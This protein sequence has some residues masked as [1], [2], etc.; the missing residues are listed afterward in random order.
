M[1]NLQVAS[2]VCGGEIYEGEESHEC[3]ICNE[4]LCHYCYEEPCYN[5][6]AHVCEKCKDKCAMCEESICA[7]CGIVHGGELGDKRYCSQDCVNKALEERK[8]V[9]VCLSHKSK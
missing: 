3:A 4:P 2:C 7:S 1:D 6:G 8:A 9:Q 5:C